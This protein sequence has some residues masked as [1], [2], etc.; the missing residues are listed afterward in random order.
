MIWGALGTVAAVIALFVFFNKGTIFFADEDPGYARIYVSARGNLSAN[1]KARH[2]HERL[3]HCQTVPGIRAVY[4]T[5]GGQGN[6]MNNQG[7]EPVDNIGHVSLEMKDYRL[8]RPGKEIE[9]EIRRKTANIP[10]VNIEIR[11]PGNGP[12]SGKDIM[13]DVSSDNYLSLAQVTTAIREHMN[14]MPGLRDVE[15]TRPL[16]G[17]EWDLDINRE[18]ASRFGANAQSIG[19]AVQLVTN[20]IMVGKYRPDDSQD[21]VDIRVRYPSESRGIAALDNLRVAAND[22]T[23]VPISNFVTRKPAQQVNSIER[24]DGHRVYH[25]PRER[26][27]WRQRE[28]GDGQDFNHG[29]TRRISPTTSACHSRAA[30]KSKTN[31]ALP[32]HRGIAGTVPDRDGSV[33]AVQ[34]LLSRRLDPDCGN[35]RHD[36]QFARHG[37]DAGAFLDHHVGHRHAGAGRYRGEPQHRAHRHIPSV[38]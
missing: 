38:A 31:P 28:R 4:A 33:D 12:S 30:R 6:S 17:I 3:A 32:S 20:G 1:E 2:R 35:P 7:G 27:T 10:G 25:V 15:D 11:E 5:S 24:V 19:T 36:R 8:R 22:G 21:E 16:P 9:E 26:E 29:S 34:Q 37:R 23:M 18:M 13:I 14:K